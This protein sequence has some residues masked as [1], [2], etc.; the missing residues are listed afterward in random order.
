M[1]K[2]VITIL[3]LGAVALGAVGCQP[4]QEQPAHLSGEE[5]I[6]T[7]PAIT[8]SGITPTGSQ[9]EPIDK[10]EETALSQEQ[11]DVIEQPADLEENDTISPDNTETQEQI[12]DVPLAEVVETVDKTS[13][14][15]EG[16]KTAPKKEDQEEGE[17]T[18][19]KSACYEKCKT[20]FTTYVD[21][22]GNVDYKS[23]RRKRILLIGAARAFE[24]LHPAEFMSWS[25]KE[26]KAFWINAYNLFTLKLIIDNYPIEPHWILRMRYPDNSIMQISNAWT[27]NYFTVMGLEYSLREIEREVL[28]ERFKDLRVCFA[29]SY[30]SM[31]S[32]FLRNEAYHAEKLDEQLD[33]QV[34]KYLANPRG[35]KFDHSN[36]IIYL[37]SLFNLYKDYFVKSEYAKIKKFREQQPNIRAYLNFTTKYMRP[38]EVKYVEAKTYT[39]KFQIYDWHLNEKK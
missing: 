33:E 34:K 37:S 25:A 23:L 3:L 31:S 14:K 4:Q 7:P 12:Q 20:I 16:E 5:V 22:E 15:S 27:D 18:F 1:I 2:S 36:R 6:I 30:A 39:V 8:D 28:L 32:A 29:L 19:T 11:A 13:T 9:K 35:L 17:F 24:D 21:K 38:E 10:A 26:K